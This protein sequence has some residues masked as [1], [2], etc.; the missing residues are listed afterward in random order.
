MSKI[1]VITGERGA[2]KSRYCLALL[3]CCEEKGLSVGGFISP[4]VYTDGIKAAFHTMDVRTREQRLCGT[5][6]APDRGTVGC[7]QM[8]ASVLEWGNELLQSSIP[9]DVLFVDELGP[10]EFEKGKGYTEALSVLENGGY[11]RAYVVIRPG[12][13]D[14]FRQIMPEF[15]V[16]TVEGG[17]CTTGPRI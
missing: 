3:E 11:S 13:L 2:G 7:W 5:R 14:A 1:T 4:A 17:A 9:C 12:C 16:I 15:D 6:T 10:L 8:D